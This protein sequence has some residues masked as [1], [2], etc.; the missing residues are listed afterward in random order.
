MSNK[1]D[2]ININKDTNLTSEKV[3]KLKNNNEQYFILN[4]KRKTYHILTYGCQMNEHDSE[5]IAGMLS[6]IGYDETSDEHNADLV[7]FN[8]CL[9]RENAELKV[10]G[11]LGEV[12]GLKR[13]KPDM[14][15]AV[16]G[17]MMQKEEIRDKVLKSFSFV[18]I[19]FGTN[20]I[21]ELPNLIYNVEVN[22]KKSVDIIDNSDLIF[23]DMPKSR[24][25]NYKALVNITYGCNNFCTYCVVPYVR[26]REK[27]REPIE[28]INEVNAL[29][30]E[31]CK[32]ITLL[33]Q[34]VN[35][36][37]NNLE[38]KFTFA[39]LL[40]ELNKI[41]GIERIRF[42]TSHP[43]DLTD[44]LVMAIKDCD[45]VCNHVHLPIQAGSNDVLKRMNRK[46]TKEHYL[47]LVKKLKSA[48]PDIAIT[49]DIIVGFP[50][51]T[52]EDF[53]ETL[54]VV[55]KAEYDSAFTFL[56][57][58]RE[59]TKAALM[60]DQIPDDIKHNRFDRLLEVLYP[61]V[62]AKNE[63]CIGKVY[64]VLVESISKTSDNFLTGR[65][66]HFRLVH[67]KGSEDLIGQMVNIKI[68][69]AKTFHMEGD[70]VK[71]K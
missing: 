28:I 9:I 13:N 5:K 68:T 21:H 37:G 58:M 62:L 51:E 59:G 44:D 19:I 47:E 71:D 50:G 70:I 45:K 25:F 48:V 36:Y 7:I 24:K 23:E 17:C 42:M 32:E 8:T 43:K 4:G 16:C 11:K 53:Q 69:S 66:E 27:S 14:I 20:T 35:S 12:K 6:S 46:Y 33:G 30:Q 61:I 15:V 31:G 56:Y 64:P 65:T 63:G 34:N 3:I 29:A 10:F 2:I 18:D 67:F 26:G 22:K 49:T 38:N 60:E 52:E 41:T 57:S 1:K 54:D 55:K 39:K 40:Y